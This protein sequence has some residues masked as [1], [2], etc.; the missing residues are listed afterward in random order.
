MGGLDQEALEQAEPCRDCPC[1][2][3]ARCTPW[4]GPDGPT[5]ALGPEDPADSARC[6]QEEA[7]EA[8]RPISGLCRQEEALEVL[9]LMAFLDL[10]RVITVLAVGPD[11]TLLHTAPLAL[12]G[13]MAPLALAGTVPLA[14]GDL[15]NMVLK[16][17]TVLVL[18]LALATVLVLIRV[19]PVLAPTLAP[20]P[21]NTA[22]LLDPTTTRLRLPPPTLTLQT[23][24]SRHLRTFPRLL[25]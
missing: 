14:L 7:L 21:A 6:R 10:G 8:R 15:A 3:W 2:P 11:S 16:D 23:R 5:A 19:L 24:P 4:E 12:E 25:L 18:V 1:T 22:P 13:S 17:S 9:V 20:T